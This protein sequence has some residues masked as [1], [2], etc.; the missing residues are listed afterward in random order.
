MAALAT[1]KPGSPFITPLRLREL[2]GMMLRFRAAESDTRLLFAKK[3]WP[4]KRQPLLEHSAM[5]AGCFS[6]LHAGDIV[7]PASCALAANLAAGAPVLDLVKILAAQAATPDDKGMSPSE[8]IA[9]VAGA[10]QAQRVLGQGVVACLLEDSLV[11]DSSVAQIW[12]RCVARE[13]PLL[14]LTV[15]RTMPEPGGVHPLSGMAQIAVGADDAPAI[16]RVMQES[17][18]RARTGIGPTWIRC[19]ETGAD[20]LESMRVFL[21]TRGHFDSGQPRLERTAWA[22]EWK[23][24]CKQ[25]F[26]AKTSGE[27]FKARVLSFDPFR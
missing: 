15:S 21:E 22:S 2:Y 8:G 13:L 17:I 9:M 7:A 18:H 20:P 10:A 5:L 24:A 4:K 23:A 6:H 27:P 14:I 12:R 19:V 25:A 26:D 11:R 16:Y 1:Q 3:K